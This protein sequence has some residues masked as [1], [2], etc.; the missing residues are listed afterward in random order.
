M[1]DNPFDDLAAA[2][3]SDARDA[4]VETE[5]DDGDETPTAG[6]SPADVTQPEQATRPSEADAESEDD[7]LSGPAFEYAEV[8]QRPLYARG[9]TWDAFEDAVGITV[10]PEL[11]KAGVRDE[12]I[13]E[14]HDAALRLAV[15]EPEQV[16]ELVLEAREA[17]E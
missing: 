15:A 1:T 12:E 7:D 10:V 9:Q 3:S 8:R 4:G 5:S 16:A 13:R 17:S 14:L 11:R 2:D 6:S